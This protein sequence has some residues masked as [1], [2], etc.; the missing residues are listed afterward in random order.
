[1]SLIQ[2]LHPAG[3]SETSEDLHGF[4]EVLVE[5]FTNVRYV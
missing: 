4:H 3:T 5:V 2:V 1:M